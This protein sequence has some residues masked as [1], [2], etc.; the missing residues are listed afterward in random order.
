[1]TPQAHFRYVVLCHVVLTRKHH[2]ASHCPNIIMTAPDVPCGP[3]QLWVESNN[4]TFAADCLNPHINF[5][6]QFANANPFFGDHE[7]SVFIAR[8]DPATESSLLEWAAELPKPSGW[9]TN[10]VNL[11]RNEIQRR[12]TAALL[13]DTNLDSKLLEPTTE[14]NSI[15]RI[16]DHY[17]HS[18]E[19]FNDETE[20][21]QELQFDALAYLVQHNVPLESECMIQLRIQRIEQVEFEEADELDDGGVAYQR[22]SEEYEKLNHRNGHR[23]VDAVELFKMWFPLDEDQLN[24]LGNQHLQTAAVSQSSPSTDSASEAV[25]SSPHIIRVRHDGNFSMML[26][27]TAKYNYILAF[28]TS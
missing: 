5:I 24:T 15:S 23:P 2:P 26:V 9:L 12:K 10:C 19:R 27:R 3:P 20:A 18:F 4:G 25:S 8:R 22:V 28:A 21:D 6:S 7:F 16:M 17:G 11:M 1:M 14:L 13:G